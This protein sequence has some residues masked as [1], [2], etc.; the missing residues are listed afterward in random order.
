MKQELFYVSA[1]RG[2]EG[3]S[4]ITSDIDRLRESLGISMA[5]PSAIELAEGLSHNAGIETSMGSVLSHVMDKAE[6]KDEFHHGL[7]LGL[8]L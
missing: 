1:S 4:I 3:I 2:R 6:S 7:G 5:R 8:G